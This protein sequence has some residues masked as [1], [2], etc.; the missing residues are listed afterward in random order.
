MCSVLHWDKKIELFDWKS[1]CIHYMFIMRCIMYVLCTLPMYHLSTRDHNLYTFAQ[2]TQCLYIRSYFMSR[3][4][5]FIHVH[6]SDFARKQ[7][8]MDMYYQIDSIC[9]CLSKCEY[10]DFITLFISVREINLHA[11][12]SWVHCDI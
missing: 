11:E 6:V 2:S 3:M 8:K 9:V 10:Y 4:I 12:K 5:L 1:L 7:W